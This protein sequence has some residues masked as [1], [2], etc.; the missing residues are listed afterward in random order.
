MTDYGLTAI[1][2]PGPRHH[3]SATFGALLEAPALSCGAIA[4]APALI[5]HAI[6]HVWGTAPDY[7]A[8]TTLRQFQELVQ[9]RDYPDLYRQALALGGDMDRVPELASDIVRILAA[10]TQL[11][12]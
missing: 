8:G 6:T 9:H 11:T 7:S 10:D 12:R 4:L 5:E 2:V 1:E 3:K